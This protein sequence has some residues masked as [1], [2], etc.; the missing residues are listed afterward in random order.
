MSR[1]DDRVTF[2]IAYYPEFGNI[3]NILEE[4][5][6]LLAPKEQRR[7]VITGILRIGFKN[8]KFEGSSCKFSFT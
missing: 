4:L 5:Q 2:N 7:K 3:R 8:G 6:V 1:N